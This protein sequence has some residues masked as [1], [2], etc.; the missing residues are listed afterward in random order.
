MQGLADGANMNYID[1]LMYQI[2]PDITGAGSCSGFAVFGNAT[3]DGHLY[4]G[5]NHDWG[6]PPEM[7]P[8]NTGLVI[9]HEPENG[10]A[11]VSVTSFG[12]ISVV[13]GMN[14]NGV[15]VGMKGSQSTDTAPCGMPFWL[16]LKKSCNTLIV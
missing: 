4:H 9:V 11:Y 16:M 2:G 15:T 5:R 1:V 14:I 13:S 10:N 12:Y 6:F 3:V 8:L 7:I